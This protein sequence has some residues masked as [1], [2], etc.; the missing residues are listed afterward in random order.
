MIISKQVLSEGDLFDKQKL[1]NILN[2]TV[3]LSV[4]LKFKTFF[5]NIDNRKELL[6][7]VGNHAFLDSENLMYPVVNPNTGQYDCNLI[8][9][10]KLRILQLKENDQLLESVN[11]LIYECQCNKKLNVKI[12]FSEEHQDLIE[13]ISHFELDVSE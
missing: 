8:F 11:N 4:P 10:S 13:L 12:D 7:R 5:E 6:N 2:E 3:N 1:Q 9:A